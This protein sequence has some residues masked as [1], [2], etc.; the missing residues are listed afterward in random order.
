MMKKTIRVLALIIACACLPSESGGADVDA[1]YL[2]T[3]LNTARRV[4]IRASSMQSVNFR[5]VKALDTDRDTSW[6]SAKG[7]G[8]Q[9]ISV[10]FGLKR[11]LTSIVVYPGRN[12][13]TRP[14]TRFTLQFLDG[15]WFDFAT[16][17]VSGRTEVDLG[18]VDAST[19]RIFVPADAMPDGVAA[20]A[21]IEAYIG[22]TKIS[23]YDERLKKMCL[24]IRNAYLPSD[25]AS[26][27]NAA[28][29]YRG[30]R[31]AGLDLYTR[32]ADNS[33]EPTPVTRSTPVLAADDGVVIRADHGYVPTG[34]DE[35]NRRA[36]YYRSHPS[37]F[38]RRSFG[39]R[40]VWIDHR[41]GVIT[42][43]NHLSHIEASVKK[44]G[45]VS[46]GEIIGTAGNSG[47]AG[48]ALGTDNGIHLHFEIWVDGTYLGY[49]ME[50]LDVKKYFR[51]IF[52][53]ER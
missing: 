34:I 7:D 26:Y 1:D 4:C 42:T 12:G 50:P 47:L 53:P 30:G 16:V 19:F 36:A 27:P 22:G 51:W 24:P 21:E 48:E 18:G 9:W 39:G 45:R 2:L 10:D 20:I 11:L 49:G 32:H 13:G 3:G 6:V 38:M 35:W 25:D 43:Y 17:K 37:T 44:G 33:Y 40:E 41:N 5:P 23:F 15:E 8:P 31:H 14:L 29:A 46:R 28:R 52:S